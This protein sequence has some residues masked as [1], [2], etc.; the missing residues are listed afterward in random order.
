MKS[1]KIKKNRLSLSLTLLLLTLSCATPAYVIMTRDIFQTCKPSSLLT[2]DSFEKKTKVSFLRYQKCYDH[3]DLLVIAWHK[4]NV[5]VVRSTI[6]YIL[7]IYLRKINKK[8][9][10]IQYEQWGDGFYMVLSLGG[11]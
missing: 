7:P 5:T 1:I 4:Y 3:K 8:G 6:D 11:A 2:V 10:L 9:T